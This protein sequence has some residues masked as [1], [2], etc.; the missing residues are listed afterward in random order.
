MRVS[1]NQHVTASAWREQKKLI[2]PEKEKQIPP[3]SE[4]LGEESRV[5]GFGFLMGRVCVYVK[6]Y[7]TCLRTC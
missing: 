6:G 2:N 1:E 7:A 5:K 3:D 4:S